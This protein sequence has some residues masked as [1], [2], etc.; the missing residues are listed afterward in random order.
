M[1]RISK[2]CNTIRG[3]SLVEMVVVICIIVLLASVLGVG[4]ADMIR[5]ANEADDS[6]ADASSQMV[7]NLVQNEASL[8]MYGFDKSD[9]G[10][11]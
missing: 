7:A 5:K 1:R 9:T 6:V 8:Q 3:F 4:I 11:S 10:V 2:E